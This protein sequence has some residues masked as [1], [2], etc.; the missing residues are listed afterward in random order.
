MEN[1]QGRNELKERVPVNLLEGVL[2]EKELLDL[3]GLDK[4]F[5]DYL[6]SEKKFPFCRVSMKTRFYLIEDVYEYIKSKRLILNKD[7]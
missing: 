6:R 2:T 1:D 7:E 4:L 5:L 3:F